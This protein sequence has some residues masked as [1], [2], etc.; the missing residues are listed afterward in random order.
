MNL[1]SSFVDGTQIYGMTNADSVRLRTL[2]G[3]LPEYSFNKNMKIHIN[4][5]NNFERKIEGHR[6][7]YAK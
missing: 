1:I 3:G 2:R 4:I 7:Y 6:R 5:F